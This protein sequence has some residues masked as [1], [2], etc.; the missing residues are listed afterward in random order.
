MDKVELKNLVTGEVK[1]VKV[2]KTQGF[3]TQFNYTPVDQAEQNHGDYLVDDTDYVDLQ[4]LI[5]RTKRFSPRTYNDIKQGSMMDSVY[6]RPE[7][8]IK[9]NQSLISDDE[10]TEANPEVAGD[11][12][13]ET[14]GEQ[15]QVTGEPNPV[16]GN[17]MPSG[18][19][20]EQ[21]AE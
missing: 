1:E 6:L 2:F 4:T 5:E 11:I 12:G 19:L 20:A 9:Y 13:A 21:Q 17:P 3:N 14:G 18:T 15:S 10:P 8:I 16:E 7:E